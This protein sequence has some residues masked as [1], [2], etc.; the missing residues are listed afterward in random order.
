[1]IKGI[2]GWLNFIILS[3][4]YYVLLSLLRYYLHADC[5]RWFLVMVCMFYAGGY[6]SKWK[7]DGG[8]WR[9]W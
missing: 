5:D 3:V 1:M 7:N 2:P 4:F 8:G 6:L 9:F